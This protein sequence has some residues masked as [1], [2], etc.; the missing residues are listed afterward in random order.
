[1]SIYLQ[2][3]SITV[4]HGDCLDV[5]RTQPAESVDAIVTD[6]P[7][8]IAFMGKDWDGA[9]GGREQWSAWL[10]DVMRECLRVAKP[11]AHALVWALPRT[12]HWTAC[13]LEDAGW[14]I[15]DRITHLFA[16]GFPKS[17]DVAKAIDARAS[18]NPDTARRVELVAEVIRRHR[19]AAGMTRTEVA[20]RVVGTP[21][22][23]CWN[24]EHQ[25]LPSVEMWPI[26][27]SVLSIPDQFDGLIEGDRTKF[28][29]AEREVIGQR[30]TGIGT[31]RGAVAYIADG[32]RDVT[33][34]ATED[35]RRWEG[36]GT[37]LKPAS[38]D[39][40]IARKPFQGTVAANVVT[41]GTGAINIDASR[42]PG[43]ER[44]DYGLTTA[45]RPQG[46]A[47]GTPTASADFDAS[48]G[49]WPSNVVFTHADCDGKCA[50]GCPAGELDAQ[51][52]Q[53]TAGG[54]VLAA[55]RQNDAHS[56]DYRLHQDRAW[57]GYADSGGA[58]RFFPTFRYE[59]KAPT[60]ER[61]KSDDAAHPTV[62]PLDLMRWLVRLVTP[63]GG[64]VL[65]PFLGSGTTAEACL[66]ENLRC[67]GIEREADYLPLI[68]ARLAKPIQVGLDIF[69]EGA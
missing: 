35:A 28:L 49:R 29:A 12:A 2:D 67:I 17:L 54:G 60:S 46:A 42:V 48:K 15:R 47:Y 13:G 20:E 51:S 14:E 45:S 21:S 57:E 52:G 58:S 9:K 53:R 8:G 44:T 39:W 43:R 38:E 37:A 19:E 25:Q 63:P 11:G 32:Q 4:H 69:E 7:A 27:K 50:P 31:G 36:W 41:H 66:I 24:W 55:K 5:L 1:V 56:V 61:P 40:W 30:T 23:A 68:R 59:A 62:K 16:S 10:A 64:V 33:A 6:P 65:D 34:P 26:L 22:G 18:V 3:E